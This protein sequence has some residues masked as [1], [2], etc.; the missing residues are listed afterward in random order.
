M[1]VVRVG[2]ERVRTMV[3]TI[4]QALERDKAVR[5]VEVR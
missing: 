3:G 1:G 4:E 5:V 2:V